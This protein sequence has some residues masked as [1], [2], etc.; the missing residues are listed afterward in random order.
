MSD[1]LAKVIEAEKARDAA[2]NQAATAKQNAQN[3]AQAIRA[4]AVQK[5]Q[6]DMTGAFSAAISR[7]NADLLTVKV[8]LQ[9]GFGPPRPNIIATGE[10]EVSKD[11]EV[12]GKIPFNIH[13]D[14]KLTMF[15]QYSHGGVQAAPNDPT[16]ISILGATQDEYKNLIAK[17]LGK[18]LDKI[19]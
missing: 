11:G 6:S 1:E 19:K 13:D 5:W 18:L 4:Q 9:A 2:R 14:G 16:E 17:V 7:S 10:I 8:V 3:A 12:A 15:Y